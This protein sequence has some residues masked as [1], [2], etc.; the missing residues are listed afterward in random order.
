VKTNEAAITSQLASI[1]VTQATLNQDQV[2]LGYTNIYAPIDGIVINRKVDIGQTVVSNNAATSMFQIAADLTKMQVKA[3]IDE[4]DVG[5]LRPGQ[6]VTFRV[7]AFP[8]KEFVG[9]VAQVRLQPVVSQNVVTYTTMINVPNPNLELKP[10]MTANVK[11]EIAKAENVLRIPAGALRFR[12]TRET[13]ETMKLPVPPELNR[14]A[15][16]GQGG[17]QRGGQNAMAGGQPAPPVGQPSQSGRAAGALERGGGDRAT[18]T[19]GAQ[20]PADRQGMTRGGGQPGQA[21]ERQS[22]GR[23]G[24]GGQGQGGGRGGQGG[25]QMTPEERQKR[26]QERLAQMTPE[27]RAQYEERM[28][29]FGQGGRGSGGQGAPSGGR[30]QVAQNEQGGA[31]TRGSFGMGGGRNRPAANES[32]PTEGIADRGATTIDALFGPLTFSES[33]ARVWVY[34]VDPT[35]KAK[36]LKSIMVR[37]RIDDGTLHELVSGEGI[38]EG[39]MLVTSIDLGLAGSATRPNAIN[40]FGQPGRGGMGGGGMPGGGGGG[41]GR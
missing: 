7:D 5:L 2:N 29:Q 14:G 37:T 19:P 8:N 20:Q 38:T 31:V 30:G 15:G 12:A 17:A 13:F 32:G 23:G 28:K 21:G 9:S 18:T 40:P 27:Q 33:S 24:E 4:S 11:I 34:T 6:R 22:A 35:T 25:E 36:S 10:G 41:R 3:S 26:M 1:K 16:R 39:M